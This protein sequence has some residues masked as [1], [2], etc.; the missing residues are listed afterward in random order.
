[1][2]LGPHVQGRRN[3]TRSCK[4]RLVLLGYEDPD[5]GQFATYLPT[6][7]RESKAII[8]TLAAHRRW[9]IFSL[10]ARTAFLNGR[11][12]VRPR[13]LYVQLPAD[14]ESFLEREY[15]EGPGPRALLKSAYGLGEAPLEFFYVLVDDV[16]IAGFY[17]MQSDPCLICAVLQ[18]A[19]STRCSWFC[20][21]GHPLSTDRGYHRG[22]CG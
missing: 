8:Y 16:V 1:M 11:S 13:P 18:E 10:G 5:A 4:A 2:P 7:R 12:S 19:V 3:A 21:F 15:G 20:P 14:C 22:S 6:V 17:Q 9:R